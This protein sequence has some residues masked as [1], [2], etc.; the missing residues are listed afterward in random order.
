MWNALGVFLGLAEDH[1]IEQQQPQQP[2]APPPRPP[3]A[4]VT[5]VDLEVRRM[6]E[7]IKEV[8]RE[9]HRDRRALERK[10][11][12]AILKLKLAAEKGNKGEAHRIAKSMVQ[13]RRHAIRLDRTC[14]RLEGMAQKMQALQASATVAVYFKKSA[15]IVQTLN[16]FMTSERIGQLSQEMERGMETFNMTQEMLDETLNAM[17]EADAEAFAAEDEEDGDALSENAIVEQIFTDAGLSFQDM[18]P[19]VPAAAMPEKDT[20]VSA[21]SLASNAAV[22][23][24]EGN[25]N[26]NS[27]NSDDTDLL[28]RMNRLKDR[29]KD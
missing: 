24:S 21:A 6:N 11:N 28:E 1:A 8:T 16:T 14:T 23:V 4:P 12:S 3:R 27:S 29:R 19:D 10:E 7:M 9:I 15:A 5:P 18:M 20:R 17:D 25:N 2:A 26:N 13:S 22:P